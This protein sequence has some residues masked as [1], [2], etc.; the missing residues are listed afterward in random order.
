MAKKTTKIKI[1]LSAMGVE[2]L[3]AE[4]KK[5]R[6]E[7]MRSKLEKEKGKNKNI[8]IFWANRKKIARILTELNLK[9]FR[10]QA[11]NAKMQKPI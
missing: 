9:L 8:K 3:Q 11:L 5:A 7:M 4:L 1:D 6:Q 10:Q 2:E